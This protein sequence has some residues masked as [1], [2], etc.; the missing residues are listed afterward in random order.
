MPRG[1]YRCGWFLK[2]VEIVR[3]RDEPLRLPGTVSTRVAVGRRTP[4]RRPV[5]LVLG[6]RVR[7][8]SCAF[9]MRRPACWRVASS[10]TRRP[11]CPSPDVGWPPSASAC[12]A[13]SR[14]RR[15]D[16]PSRHIG[17]RV[18]CRPNDRGEEREARRPALASAARRGRHAPRRRSGG[19]ERAMA[20]SSRWWVLSG[21][22]L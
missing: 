15:A 10:R 20:S 2:A 1:T 18:S 21:C 8:L 5:G 19:M 3:G 4:V 11:R 22:S 14:P 6:P 16:R 9:E 13:R 7:R 17:P 12:A